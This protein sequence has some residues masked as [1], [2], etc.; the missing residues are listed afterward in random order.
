MSALE[1]MYKIYVWVA[2]YASEDAFRFYVSLL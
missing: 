2:A 1:Q